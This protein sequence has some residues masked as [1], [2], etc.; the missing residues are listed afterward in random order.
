MLVVKMKIYLLGSHLYGC[1]GFY[2]ANAASLIR[3]NNNA[4]GN[5]NGVINTLLLI[6]LRYKIGQLVLLLQNFT[7]TNLSLKLA[8]ICVITP[9]SIGFLQFHSTL[10][11]RNTPIRPRCCSFKTLEFFI[12]IP[13][14]FC[15]NI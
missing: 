15:A 13:F 6:H 14:T 12:I 4:V 9:I 2:A 7:D 8:A 5:S 1:A 10:K 11:C 3:Q